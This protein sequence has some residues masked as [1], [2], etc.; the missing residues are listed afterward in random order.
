MTENTE[1]KKWKSD[2]TI[3]LPLPRKKKERKRKEKKVKSCSNFIE[4]ADILSDISIIA[5]KKRFVNSIW[6]KILII[7]R[8][9]FD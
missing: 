6:K 1:K 7:Y 5:H 8:F 9:F 4:T 3:A 2:L